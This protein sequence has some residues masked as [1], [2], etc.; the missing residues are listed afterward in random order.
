M[1]KLPS[2]T[3]RL[4]LNVAF[5]FDDA[6]SILDYLSALGV[7]HVYCSPYLQATPGSMHGYDVVD[8]ERVNAELGGSEGQERFCNN[9]KERGLGQILDIVPNHMAVA[10]NNPY[11]RD[12]LE[13]G[14][15][16]RYADFFDL[17]WDA[18]EQRMRNKILLP[19]LSDQYGLVLKAG[20]IQ[21]I[22]HNSQFEVAYGEEHLPIAVSSISTILMP[23][24][25]AARSEKLGFLADAFDRLG[26]RDADGYEAVQKLY[27]DQRVLY[28]DLAQCLREEPLASDAVE[29][30]VSAIN[31]NLDTLDGFLQKQNYRLAH[32][33]A[34][35]QDLGYRRFFDVN[36]LIGI[37]VEDARV[38]LSTHDLVL[39]W[40]R[41]GM[42]DGVRV[43]HCDGLQNPQQYFERLRDEAPDA[44]I[45]AEKILARNET[46]PEEWPIAGTTGYDFA[47]LVNGLLVSPWGLNELNRL[48]DEI[49]G[50]K[51]PYATQVHDKKISV[52]QDSLGSDVNRL[53]GIF[54]EICESDRDHRDYT[55]AEIRQAIQEISAA[56]PVYRTYVLPDQ[57][58]RAFDAAVITTTV[59]SAARARPD[60]DGRLFKFIA[61]VLM[62]RRRGPLESTFLLHFQQFSS[63][64]MAKG[65]EDTMLYCY[66][67]LV[68]LNEVGSNPEKPLVTVEEF[69]KRNLQMQRRRPAGMVTLSTHD[70]KR[71]EDVRARLAVLSEV[72][73]LFS[74]TVQSWF[75]SNTDARSNGMPDSNTEY[76]YYQTLIGAWPLTLE[77]AKT[78]MQ[79][80]TREAKE[81]TSWTLPNKAFEDALNRF[82]DK[83]FS[84]KRFMRSV[85]SFVGRIQ[86]AGRIN[87]LS[88]TLL[89]YTVPGVPDLYQGSE[90]WDHRLVDPDNRTPVDYSARATL[91]S[92][93]DTLSIGQIM[94]RM[95]DGLPKLWTIRQALRVRRDYAAC[96][97]PRGH[98]T[99]LLPH[100]SKSDHLVAFLRGSKVL[101]CVQRLSF[102]IASP[103][104]W[105]DTTI[106]L[107]K[108]K[109]LNT[110]SGE[111]YRGGVTLASDIFSAFPV[112]LLVKE[113]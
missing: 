99:R 53:T 76:L 61:D 28:A 56:L 36:S 80:A 30:A 41:A 13:N 33:R 17:E 57:A 20:S 70:T 96:F 94:E 21:L 8:F 40:L 38:F 48:Y 72:P 79:K 11:W 112:A 93:L 88:Q 85:E 107:P 69:H 16:S 89:K 68:G 26:D 78:Y 86:H 54:L 108:G 44:W 111:L 113:K 39:R 103:Q 87:S 37:R 104:A 91:L 23:A 29:S 74:E 81:Q 63:A 102:G 24:A 35:D 25:Q 75:E 62:L 31:G 65:F 84:N 67:R 6:I 101:T 7:S 10:Q 83:T 50:G 19:I 18:G 34:A 92:E 82:I 5:T 97:G 46:L 22:H 1:T 51:T 73:D 77:R 9:L 4:Q 66:N 2:S 64:V 32:W 12:V 3:Y 106:D 90:L 58:V 52:T 105:E 45:V 43:D 15:R 47:N 27:R 71:N 98:Y 95:E 60:L 110:L 14:R 100:C 42:L 109:W 49:T 59:D 55:R